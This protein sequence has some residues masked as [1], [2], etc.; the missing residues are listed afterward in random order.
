MLP[1]A[2]ACALPVI[3]SD[4]GGIPEVVQR[5][6]VSGI[7]VP[8]GDIH[9]L[10]EAMR[11]LLHDESL[12]V[13]SARRRAGES[14]SVH[15]RADGGANTRRISSCDRPSTPISRQR[16]VTP[17]GALGGEIGR[18]RAGRRGSWLGGQAAFLMAQGPVLQ[19]KR[20]PVA[21]RGRNRLPRTQRTLHP[22][23]PE[24]GVPSRRA[25]ALW[26][27]KMRIEHYP[28]VWR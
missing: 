1:Q 23:L 7:L 12:L 10:T 15:R 24:H 28:A 3:A 11:T 2:M 13:G 4:I 26:V 22:H 8:P 16:I 20:S 5:S 19:P 21:R 25:G 18:H 9:Q 6:G 14:S 17:L 27:E